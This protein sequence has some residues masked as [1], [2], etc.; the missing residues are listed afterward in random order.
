MHSNEIW[1]ASQCL[2]HEESA[3]DVIHTH[4]NELGYQT[5]KVISHTRSHWQRGHRQ[6]VVSLVDDAWDCAEDR[7]Q[8]TP[9]LFDADT[10]VITDNWINTPTVYTV[11]RVPDSFYGIYSYQPADQTWQPD[12]DYSFGVNRLEFKRMRILLNLYHTLGVDRGYV[13]FN[14][15]V[16]MR[17]SH[18][19][20]QLQQHFLDQ[21]VHANPKE[22]KSLD[23]LAKHMPIKNYTIHHDQIYTRSWLNIIVETYSSDNVVALS[24]KIFR[25]LVTPVPWISYSGR[26]TIARLR[27]LGFD[28]LDDIVD[29]RYDQLIEAHHKI[30]AFMDTACT[31]INALKQHD[32]TTLSQRCQTAAAHNR[33]QLAEMKSAWP[34]DFAAWLSDRIT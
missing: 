27:A 33:Q 14:C 32:W 10:T 8:D 1:Q 9:Y 7:S 6:V 31:T 28:V 5:T 22:L 16:D 30:S 21:L 23:Q 24:E 19:V 15:E 2:E 25:C 17:A 3:V 12:R 34:T 26:Y 11:A 13:N 20:A 18:S 29:H 4:L